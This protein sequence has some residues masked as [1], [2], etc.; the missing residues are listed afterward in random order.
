MGRRKD[1]DCEPQRTN[2]TWRARLKRS[3]LCR[4][5]CQTAV[6]MVVLKYVSVIEKQDV[7]RVLLKRCCPACIPA[8][9]TS[10]DVPTAIRDI[11]ADPD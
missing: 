8:S 5:S 11:D 7:A 3:C 1:E 2:W 9:W 6:E 10:R 4:G